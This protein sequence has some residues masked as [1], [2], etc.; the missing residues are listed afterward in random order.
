M[1]VLF[2]FWVWLAVSGSYFLL[3]V[4]H[5]ACDITCTVVT[6]S[7][8]CWGN[9]YEQCTVMKSSIDLL[10]LLLQ[11]LE[12]SGNTHQCCL[13]FTVHSMSQQYVT[14]RPPANTHVEQPLLSN[15]KVTTWRT[16]T[17]CCLL[18]LLLA[19]LSTSSL[20]SMC[21]AGCIKHRGEN[22]G[23][24]SPNKKHKQHHIYNWRL[25]IIFIILDWYNFVLLKSSITPLGRYSS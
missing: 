3:F 19:S 23:E 7:F 8:S 14:E 2:S 12:D 22:S 20:H 6:N 1:Q 18:L 21:V 10:F 13:V 5:F 4:Q 25:G 15:N 9:R 24:I 16:W 11:C 17:S